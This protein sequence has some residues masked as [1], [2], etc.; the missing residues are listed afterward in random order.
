MKR[1]NGFLRE[2]IAMA[3]STECPFCHLK[4]QGVPHDLAGSSSECPRC[5]NLFTLSVSTA[6]AEEAAV[7]PRRI[8]RKRAP[9]RKDESPTGALPPVMEPVSSDR[10][11]GDWTQ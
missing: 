2:G 1:R 8:V 6:P 9:V 5:H 10:P 4:M 3:F 11:L 7:G